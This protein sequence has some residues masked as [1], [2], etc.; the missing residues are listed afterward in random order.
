MGKRDV[1]GLSALAVKDLIPGLPGEFA[2]R[3]PR[4]FHGLRHPVRLQCGHAQAGYPAC[5]S[6]FE[7]ST[8]PG[9]MVRVPVSE[10][11]RPVSSTLY[12]LS[13]IP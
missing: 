12:T 6:L 9:E 7:T 13:V 1:L 3:R 11:T 8:P 5:M 4:L 10:V 2:L